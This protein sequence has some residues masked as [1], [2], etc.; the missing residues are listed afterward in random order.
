MCNVAIVGMDFI[1][2]YGVG[3]GHCFEQLM[4]GASAIENNSRFCTD[5]FISSLAALI[6]GLEYYAGDSLLQ[7]MLLVLQQHVTVDIPRDSRVLVATTTGEIDLLERDIDFRVGGINSLPRRVKNIFSLNR[8][9]G[10]V[11]SAACASSSVALAYAAELISSGRE[12]SVL[13]VAGDCVSEFVFAG[14]SALMALDAEMARPF[15]VRRHGL[16]VGEAA[17]YMLVMNKNLA[18]KQGRN[19]LGSVSGWGISNDAN[20]MTGPSRDGEGLARAIGEALRV[21]GCTAK[22]ISAI[23]AH[24]TG[25]L[26]ND[27]MELKAFAKIFSKPIPTHSIKGGTGHTMGCAG[28]L[29]IGIGLLSLQAGL[30]PPTVNLEEVMSEGVDWLSGNCQNIS[31]GGILSVNSGFGG[32]NVAVILKGGDV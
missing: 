18:Q 2:G 20:H 23:S 21:A 11:I 29:E 24:G 32:V 26:Y 8:D 16:N 9:D 5:K 19:I 3:I 14:F 31:K 25:T 4:A 17:G 12:D 30:I 7:K 1:T 6:P 28:L 15:D 13:V 10:K 27:A 22:D